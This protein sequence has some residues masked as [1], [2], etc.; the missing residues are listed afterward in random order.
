MT[1]I[2]LLAIGIAVVTALL[3]SVA[4]QFLTPSSDAVLSPQEQK[5]QQI[6]NE[7][8]KIHATY[9]DSNPADLPIDDRN[10]MTHLDE[11]WMKECVS[12]LPGDSITRIANNVERDVSYGE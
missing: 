8:Y 12:I 9:P 4:F 3:G 11:I 10:R 1:S 5:C 6:A 2:L 7:G